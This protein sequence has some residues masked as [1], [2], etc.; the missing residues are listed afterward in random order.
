MEHDYLD[1]PSIMLVNPSKRRK[2]RKMTAK[3]RRYFGNPHRR[4]HHHVRRTR[5]HYRHNPT[6]GNIGSSVMPTL[7]GGLIGAVGGLGADVVYG[8]AS[9]S[10]TALPTFAA[11]PAV[12]TAGKLA[13][14]ILI[15]I[16][17]NMVMKGR[18][19]ELA[20]GAATCAIHDFAKSQLAAAMPSLPLGDYITT[21]PTVGV[22]GLRAF[23]RNYK[24]VG[25][26]ITGR[27]ARRALPAP[28]RGRSG[29]GQYLAD[30][31]FSNGIPV[32]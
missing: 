8:L 6:M 20:V 25:S 4:R 19:G 5:H 14:A 18:G 28:Q 1:N 27:G 3:Q 12:A 10:I 16:V 9:N 11:N 15:G 29:M 21:A 7:K 30:T 31:T 26:Y 13:T 2:R 22:R 17:G 23:N 32:A 24:P